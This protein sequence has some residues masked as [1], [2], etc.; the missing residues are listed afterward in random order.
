MK[1]DTT[2]LALLAGPV[3]ISLASRDSDLRPSV[4]HGYG[5]RIAGGG[6]DVRVFA[7]RS[8]AGPV[9]F[10]IATNGHVATVFSD[11]RSFR[12]L[13]LKGRGLVVPFD[14]RD[15]EH[16]EMHYRITSDEL[17]ALGHPQGPARSYFSAPDLADFVT[18]SFKPVDIFRQT[19]GPD[20]GARIC[21]GTPFDERVLA[22][23][24]A[25]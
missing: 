3:A 18:V 9:L 22:P 6:K 7:L 11:V 14:A 8:E 20:A 4:A 19:P 5:C 23:A 24:G 10:D 2:I 21:G 16:R 1:L 25:M 13:Q 17:V 12:S 15:A